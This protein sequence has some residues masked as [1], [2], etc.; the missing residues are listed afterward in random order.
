[1]ILFD[2]SYYE[3]LLIV[4]CHKC[5]SLQNY[6]SIAIWACHANASFVLTKTARSSVV[7]CLHAKSNTWTANSCWKINCRGLVQS[8]GHRESFMFM[9]VLNLSRNRNEH[10]PVYS[11]NRW[12]HW[13]PIITGLVATCA[14]RELD[15]LAASLCLIPCS[16][17]LVTRTY[18][19]WEK[20]QVF[21]FWLLS[22]NLNLLITCQ[23][24]N[25][26]AA[27][28]NIFTWT[29][30]LCVWSVFASLYN[31][32]SHWRSSVCWSID[33]KYFGIFV[34][35]PFHRNL[36]QSSLLFLWVIYN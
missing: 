20:K 4:T 19:K 35:F 9:E 34:V 23:C 3:F 6:W 1:M 10:F 21:K 2:E 13:N 14:T 25:P 24:S 17:K 29:M 5:G 26:W 11:Q 16:F 30:I 28:Q 7:L 31:F 15:K 18:Y 8:N 22:W 32:L 36:V 33:I 12:C 27:F